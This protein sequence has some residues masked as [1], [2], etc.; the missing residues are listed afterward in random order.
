MKPLLVLGIA[1]CR[2]LALWPALDGHAVMAR[3]LVVIVAALARTLARPVGG[4]QIRPAD[5]PIEQDA[6]N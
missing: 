5:T 1:G 3:P 4:K 2:G 6:E